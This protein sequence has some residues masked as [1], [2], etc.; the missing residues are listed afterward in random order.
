MLIRS[1]KI[2]DSQSPFHHQTKDVWIEN[3]VIR[4]IGDALSVAN[5]EVLT[6]SN[7]HLSP[8]WIDMRTTT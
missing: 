8:G 4:Q 7:W 3:G 2:V 6:G 5:T 1:V